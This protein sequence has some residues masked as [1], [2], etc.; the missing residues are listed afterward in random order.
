M[1]EIKRLKPSPEQVGKV[2]QVMGLLNEILDKDA[3]QG[4]AGGKVMEVSKIDSDKTH[5]YVDVLVRIK[6]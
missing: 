1:S 2:S 4:L 5:F 3:A 6:V